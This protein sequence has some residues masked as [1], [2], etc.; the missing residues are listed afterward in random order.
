MSPTARSRGAIV[1]ACLSVLP[2]VT[3]IV[4]A[5]EDRC[6]LEREK[7]PHDPYSAECF[8]E[9]AVPAP[10]RPAV[11]ARIEAWA[12][13]TPDDPWVL[14]ARA[15]NIAETNSTSAIRIGEAASAL[16]AA[17]HDA[18]GEAYA[19][20]RM[21]YPLHRLRR[22]PEAQAA[23]DRARALDWRRGDPTLAAVA[24]RA[25]MLVLEAF[26]RTDEG[27]LVARRAIG[28]AGFS[29]AQLS[30]RWNVA[31]VASEQARRLGD[32]EDLR[33]FGLME[34]GLRTD[35]R[36]APWAVAQD[37]AKFKALLADLGLGS[38]EDARTALI[39]AYE[40]AEGTHNVWGQARFLCMIGDYATDPAE[41]RLWIDRCSARAKEFGCTSLQ[42]QAE[43]DL[44]ARLATDP[45]TREEGL[46]VAETAVAHARA[47][48]DVD[49]EFRTLATLAQVKALARPRAEVA[50]AFEDALDTLERLRSRLDDPEQRAAIFSREPTPY[51]YA[52]FLALGTAAPSDADRARAFAVLEEARGRTLEDALAGGRARS[53]ALPPGEDADVLRRIRGR[54]DEVRARIQDG[55]PA[56]AETSAAL[57]ELDVLDASETAALIALMRRDPQWKAWYRPSVAGLSEVRA[58]LDPDEA[59]VS[60]QI[61]IHSGARPWV[62]LL[63][64]R[65]VEFLRVPEEDYRAAAVLYRGLLERRDGSERAA[66]QA[67][68]SALFGAALERLGSDVRRLLVIADGPL[69]QIPIAALP[70]PR[71]GLPLVSRYEI[72]LVPSGTRWLRWKTGA[73]PLPSGDGFG[74]ADPDLSG[75]APAADADRASLLLWIA[76]RARLPRA[77]D[78]IRAMT[79]ALGGGSE[80]LSGAAASEAALKQENLRRFGVLHFAA[81][82]VV[83]QL[84]AARSAI[85]LARAAPE[86]GLLEAREIAALPLAGQLVVLSA[87]GTAEGR[88][89]AGEGALSLTHAF[90]EAGARAVISTLWPIRDAD[91]ALLVERFYTHLHAGETAAKALANAQRDR[92]AAGAPPAAWAAFELVGDGAWKLP[93]LQPGRSTPGTTSLLRWLVIGATVLVLLLAVRL[94]R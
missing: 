75:R 35:P 11:H 43:T 49:R 67:L 57:R 64:P 5:A 46:R 79:D 1:R 94:F 13:E 59:L 56:D 42:S 81:H 93:P 24:A 84:R 37:E 45:R 53:S 39:R 29:D 19:R 90:L 66:A 27:L 69:G 15:D 77:H 65:A 10:E 31:F 78:E 62:M 18:V 41:A 17:G 2:L 58:A 52:E 92:A 73:A 33:R 63:T 61:P 51:V 6:P 76:E 32:L 89:A 16:F 72:S 4:Y 80:T 44:A 40:I 3:A 91:A 12:G 88:F 85:L 50:R 87:C 83:N 74:V 9:P 71:T 30:A 34:A 14:A 25:E 21:V 48:A 38:L 68:S 54:M 20:F 47:W 8:D 60:F 82:A 70:D 7:K 22:D 86:D 26:D 36:T 55:S 23:L 28:D